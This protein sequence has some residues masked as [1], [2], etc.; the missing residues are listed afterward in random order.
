VSFENQ[1]NHLVFRTPGLSEEVGRKFFHRAESP[2]VQI[3]LAVPRRAA[4]RI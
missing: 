4:K 3:A 2:S 1:A